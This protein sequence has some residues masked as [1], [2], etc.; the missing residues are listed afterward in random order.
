MPALDPV[1]LLPVAMLNCLAGRE[2]FILHNQNKQVGNKK[3]QNAKSKAQEE[4]TLKNS[5]LKICGSVAKEI[6]SPI[7]PS[8][9]FSDKV[10]ICYTAQSHS[11]ASY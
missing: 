8:A 1:M 9:S 10:S 6:L 3:R 7:M 2:E 11:I 4:N 5:L